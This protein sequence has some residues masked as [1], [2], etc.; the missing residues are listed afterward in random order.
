MEEYRSNS[1]KSREAEP[2]VE[3][4]EK[5]L[6]P[7]ISG[8]ATTQKQTSLSKFTNSII[9]TSMEDLGSWL[10]SDVVIPWIKDGVSSMFKNGID[11]LLYGKSSGNRSGTSASKI[12]YG[13]YYSYNRSS[14][15][16][17]LRAGSNGGSLD[18][19]NIV[20]SNRGDAEAVL[21]SMEDLI[22]QFGQVS[23]GDLYELADVPC[24]NYTVNKYGWT[25]L[26]NTQVLRCRD[27][28]TIKLPKATNIN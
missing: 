9:A 22:D 26:R 1:L 2:M 15:N 24:P 21:S 12:S 25:S 8:S 20:F 6:G 5:K 28:Y 10:L 14:N 3:A 17:P 13:S 4:Q 23:V 18:Y 16:E 11:M 27:G 7:V 19:D